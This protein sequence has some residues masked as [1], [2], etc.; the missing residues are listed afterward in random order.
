M[1][2]R[3]FWVTEALPCSPRRFWSSALLVVCW[4]SGQV[5]RL[6]ALKGRL[7]LNYRDILAPLPISFVLFFGGLSLA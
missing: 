1:G 2:R 5:A 6:S 7:A 3:G 4:P